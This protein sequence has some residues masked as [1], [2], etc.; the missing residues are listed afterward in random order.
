MS[1]A[2]QAHA[3]KVPSPSTSLPGS[4]VWN[5][6]ISLAGLFIIVAAIILLLTFG[7]FTIISPSANPYID[8]IG[9][10]V[11]PGILVVGM[12]LTPLGLVLRR[13]KLLRA[14]PTLKLRLGLPRIDLN[15]AR[16][17]KAVTVFLALTLLMLPV[18]GVS[19]Y[20]GYHFTETSAF[21][22]LTCH[23]VMEPQYAAYEQSPHAR[24]ACAECHIGSG[25]G[26][27]VKAK[28]SGVRQVLA[29]WLESYSKPI[30]PAITELRPAR[31]TCEECHWPA[32]FFGSQL[33]T[34]V[35]F[36]PDEENSRREVRMMIKTG[37]ADELLGRAEG[38]HWHMALE[39]Q[40][41]YVAVDEGLQDVPWVRMT[42]PDGRQ[43]VFR[44]DG[45]SHDEPPPAGII[46]AVDCMDCHNRAA[47]LF[48]PPYESVDLFL[49]IGRIDSSL[50]FIKREAV[51]L[52]TGKYADNDDA[53]ARIRSGVKSFYEK[54]YPQ[55]AASKAAAIEKAI[56]AIEDIYDHT[57]F[58]AMKVD[59]KT[60]PENVGHM[61]SAGCFRCH[62][63]KHV[64]AEGVQI[65]SDCS[66]CHTFFNKVE[67]EESTFT[68]G[69][70][71]HSMNLF[72]H[73]TLRCEQ[74]H[75]GGRLPLC[76]ECHQSGEWLE[77]QGKE[78]FEP[79]P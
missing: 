21:C 22:G 20:H 29:V 14:D 24:V 49:D 38:I 6:F 68:E 12:V 41:E 66:V 9:L 55:I 2:E 61:Y 52:L 59:W 69:P 50:P 75:T 72:P 62:D 44:S 63:G 17:R 60:Y 8:I 42:D 70:F 27:F 58:P 16:Q 25:A 51:A 37:G 35:H 32:K 40:I 67:D 57:F 65:S 23:T 73:P 39:R 53:A 31:D 5:N 43:T 36:S 47:H 78:R 33:R 56:V 3:G 54:E 45:R 15:D 26:W 46:R 13:R 19:G 30:P 76:R 77:Q 34:R 48:R 64:S 79:R 4:P 10:M 7:L 18:L 1:D 74:C 11:L 28:L 71:T